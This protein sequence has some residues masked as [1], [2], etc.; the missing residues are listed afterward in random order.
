MAEGERPVT[1]LLHAWQ[2]GDATALD[3][4]MVVVY[5]E[6]HR[7]AARHLRHEQPGHTFAPTDLVSE[8]F[9]RLAGGLAP[10][11]HDREHFFAIAARNMRQILVDHARK[12]STARRGDG[13]RAIT[14]DEELVG[15]GRSDELLALDEA[16]AALAE[17][18]E[19]KARA[20]EL[21]YFGGMTRDEIGVVL[22]VHG[23]TVASDL[24]LGAAWIHRYLAHG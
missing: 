21:H 7:I 19:R 14:L 15:S 3:R 18:D 8:A 23:N 4:L 11:L 13:A 2:R 12:R 17:V 24:R 9:L 10:A 5:D 20:I 16:L 6:L 1:E 22:G